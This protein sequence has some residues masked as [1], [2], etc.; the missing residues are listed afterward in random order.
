M[1]WTRWQDRCRFGTRVILTFGEGKCR[2]HPQVG[3]GT[4]SLP[5]PAAARTLPERP[6]LP[7]ARPPRPVLVAS[8]SRS[9]NRPAAPAHFHV[10]GL[11]CTSTS[12][13]GRSMTSGTLLSGEQP[14][15]RQRRCGFRHTYQEMRRPNTQAGRSV[16]TVVVPADDWPRDGWPSAPLLSLACR[17]R[18]IPLFSF[19]DLAFLP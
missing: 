5:M 3:S 6:A 9:R 18:A 8:R 12:C 10:T 15:C 13:S 7:S 4:T 11:L 1:P 19:S 16:A 2:F 17:G 14:P